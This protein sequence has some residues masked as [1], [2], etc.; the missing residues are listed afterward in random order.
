MSIYFV[1]NVF[2]FRISFKS[3]ISNN[4]NNYKSLKK[5][6]TSNFKSV[7]KL[8]KMFANWF[9]LVSKIKSKNIAI[10]LFLFTVVSF[11]FKQ[12]AHF[13]C[14]HNVD[15]SNYIISVFFFSIKLMENV[16]RL[17]RRRNKKPVWSRK[18]FNI[19][20]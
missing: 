16:Q 15:L 12:L 10:S 11:A 4:A 2:I 6:Q 20:K 18:C 19:C 3:F 14:K 5:S 9:Y 1:Q 7:Q 13:C 8:E 17:K